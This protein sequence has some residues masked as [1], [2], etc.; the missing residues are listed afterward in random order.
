[1]SHECPACAAS[2]PVRHVVCQECWK[3]VPKERKAR[4][5]LAKQSSEEWLLAAR[6]AIR[7]VV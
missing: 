7:S 1:M 6:D 2:C 4:L 5:W 3:R